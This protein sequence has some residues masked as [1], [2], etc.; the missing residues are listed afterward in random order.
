MLRMA[1]VGTGWAG[2]RHVE[3]IR[4]LGRKVEV[5]CLVDPDAEFLQGKAEELGIEK[6]YTDLDDALQEDQIDAVSI[7]SPH[8]FH[9]AQ[10]IAAAAAGKHVLCEKPIAVT[11]EEATQ[12]LAA[13]A[14]HGVKLYVAE[15]A[16]YMPMAK[17][18]KKVV[19]TGRQIGELTSA[20]M[21]KGFRAPQYGYPGRRAWLAEPKLGGLGTWQLHGIHSMGQLRF[22][23]GEVKS[24]YMQEHKASS[25]ERRNL[26][27]TMS[28]LLTLRSGVQVSV[29]QTAETKLYGGLGGYVLH[30]D[31]GSMRA[32]EE[33]YQL[34]DDEQDGTKRSY[35]E[36]E[37]SSYAQEIEAFA[38]Y[39]TDGVEGPTTGLMERRSLAIVQA[40]YESAESGKVIDLEERF[41]KL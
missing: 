6:T 15:N 16:S 21:V 25:F 20:S 10:A 39:A 35:P 32:G 40:G 37:L 17:F 31:R 4:E 2:S 18:L 38:D 34:F 26:E 5:A 28:G 27:G 11:V 1:I 24:V 23:L 33:Q 30:G 8:P 7:C 13:A 9:C 41:G 19:Q 12:M 36:E 29:L 3:A 22:I 14:E